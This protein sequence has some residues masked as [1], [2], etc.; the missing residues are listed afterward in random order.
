MVLISCSVPKELRKERAD[1]DFKNWDKHFKDRAFCLCQLHGFNNSTMD[2]LLQQY[3]RSYYNVIAIS[4]FDEAL[5]P[6]IAKEVEAMRLDSIDVVGRIPTDILPHYQKRK[7]AQ[8]C[9]A[10]YNSKR[11]DRLTQRQKEYWNSIPS[12]IG[13]IWQKFPTY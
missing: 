3:D 13:G 6:Q 4:F 10:F 5:A 11:L 12:I 7:V 9:L 8:H 2:S 1:A